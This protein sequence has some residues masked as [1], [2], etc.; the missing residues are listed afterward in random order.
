MLV[1]LAMIGWLLL[2][3]AVG[4]QDWPQDARSQAEKAD[5][6]VGEDS[7]AI[8]D[9]EPIRTPDPQPTGI[10]SSQGAPPP[11]DPL[12]GEERP[13][14]DEDRPEVDTV[15]AEDASAADEHATDAAEPGERPLWEQ[16]GGQLERPADLFDRFPATGGVPDEMPGARPRQPEAPARPVEPFAAEAE[17]ERP[18]P[19]TQRTLAS[20]LLAAA[21]DPPGLEP[22]E[23]RGTTLL[24]ALGNTR[25]PSRRRAIT[26]AYWDLSAAMANEGIE[27][28]RHGILDGLQEVMDDDPLFQTMLAASRAAVSEAELKVVSARHQLGQETGMGDSLPLLPVDR[29]YTGRYRTRFEQLFAAR[30]P[31]AQA[32]LLNRTLPIRQQALEARAEAVQAAWDALEGA[33]D[34]VEA[35]QSGAAELLEILDQ[36]G[37]QYRSL[38]ELARQYNHE[39]VAYA[40]VAVAYPVANDTLVRMLIPATTPAATAPPERAAPVGRAGERPATT[41][42][43][44]A[45][46]AGFEDTPA[47]PPFSPSSQE[48]PPAAPRELPRDLGTLRPAAP[49]RSMAPGGGAAPLDE[50][51]SAEDGLQPD[52]P[53]VP[54]PPRDDQ[55]ASRPAADTDRPSSRH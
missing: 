28:Q 12:A 14:E 15:P 36:W 40:S 2:I 41:I 31:P 48:A 13:A 45:A 49:P 52:P 7:D 20:D 55:P 23:G 22:V 29:P 38:A 44:Q 8:P 9:P 10:G 19:P 37:G 6:A 43:P 17:P 47:T 53:L 26:R 34:E 33:L 24:A 42:E 50:V 5:F 30:V 32:R 18:P 11:W 39:I 3:G 16:P 1:T 46:P 51:L 27:R 54:V 21:L 25:D 35:G 4:A